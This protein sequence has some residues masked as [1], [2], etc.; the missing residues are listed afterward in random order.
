M[1]GGGLL[2][3]VLS[4][5][6]VRRL[7]PQNVAEVTKLTLKNTEYLFGDTSVEKQL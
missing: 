2:A 3:F 7:G 5:N 1:H 6:N 4:P